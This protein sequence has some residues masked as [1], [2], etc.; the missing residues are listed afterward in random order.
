MCDV[1]LGHCATAAATG[2]ESC[3]VVLV[4]MLQMVTVVTGLRVDAELW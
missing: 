2:P 4:S 1:C 3:Y